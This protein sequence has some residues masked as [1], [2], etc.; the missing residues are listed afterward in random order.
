MEP[1]RSH[2]PFPVAATPG[3]RLADRGPEGLELAGHGDA[4]IEAWRRPR[5]PSWATAARRRRA[6]RRGHCRRVSR[7]ASRASRG[8]PE[9]AGRALSGRGVCSYGSLR[10]MRRSFLDLVGQAGRGWAGRLHARSRSPMGTRGVHEGGSRC[11][12]VGRRCTAALR[13][14]ASPCQPGPGDQHRSPLRLYSKP[15]SPR[16]PGTMRLR[17]H[18]CKMLLSAMGRCGRGS[19]LRP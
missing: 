12:R 7:H 19:P 5:Q 6:L 13:R 16:R 18:L 14:R 2:Q 10:P 9:P 8:S 4:A 17:A 11:Q 3:E 15:A 1:I